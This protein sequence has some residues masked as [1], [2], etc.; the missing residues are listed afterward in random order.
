MIPE[1]LKLRVPVIAAPMFLVSGPQL[2]IESCKAG[3]VGS[4][5]SLNC[6][7]PQILEDWIMEIK[8]NTKNPFAINLIVHKTN[9]MMLE[10]LQIIAK[11][12]VPIVITS[13]GAVKEV[14]DKVHEYNGLVYHD[15]TSIQ[16]AEKAVKAGVDGLIAVCAGAGGHAGVCSP[17]AL[18]PALKKYNKTLICAGAIS[19]GSSIRAA[20]VMGADLVY[21]GTRFIATR[22]SMA[23]IK[24]KRM[25]LE[26]KN[27]KT[28]KPSYLPIVY[29][30]KVSGVYANFL[31]ATVKETN[32]V[33][34]D[35]SKL[36]ETAWK[37]IWSAG[38]GVLEIEDIPTVEELVLR[39]EMEYKKS[40]I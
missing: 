11:H 9:K 30:D 34:E 15:V 19:N 14:V 8:Q 10:H 18:I 31:R 25:I 12:K 16:H 28:E 40:K 21:M 5:P 29:T 3:I 2:V 13:L 1:I 35:F 6:R 27:H 32:Q 33:E 37:N 20:Q 39:L 26:A 38:H 23:S 36:G 22:E 24:Y 7:T 4:F 17:F